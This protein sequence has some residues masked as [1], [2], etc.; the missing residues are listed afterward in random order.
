MD[1][2]RHLVG[3]LTPLQV[4]RLEAAGLLVRRFGRAAGDAT[5][6]QVSGKVADAR[7]MLDNE[8]DAGAA[9]RLAMQQVPPVALP[10]DVLCALI[11]AALGSTLT[12]DETAALTALRAR[13]G[14]DA[15]RL[16]GLR[17]AKTLIEVE[18][19]MGKPLWPT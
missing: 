7:A 4:R 12:A 3:D 11:S 6:W 8:S 16:S 17:R 10:A 14:A 19:A 13:L 5:R 15:Q 9:K 1:T 18:Q 2:D